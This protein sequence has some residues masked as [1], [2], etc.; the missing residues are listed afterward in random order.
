L[1]CDYLIAQEK[2]QLKK[3]PRRARQKKQTLVSQKIFFLFVFRRAAR[4]PRK[5][6][7][8]FSLNVF[9]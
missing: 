3:R 1:I 6:F 5:N 9:F 2:N 8:F 4:G 7:I